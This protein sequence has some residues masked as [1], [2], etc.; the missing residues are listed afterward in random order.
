MKQG[1]LMGFPKLICLFTN[2]NCGETPGK[3]M[4]ILKL[5]LLITS[6]TNCDES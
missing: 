5:K 4:G 1:D 6:V 3:Q 2:S